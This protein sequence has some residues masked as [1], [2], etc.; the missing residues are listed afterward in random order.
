MEKKYF[1]FKIIAFE[2]IAGNSPYFDENTC[3]QE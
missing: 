3:D 2:V 1:L